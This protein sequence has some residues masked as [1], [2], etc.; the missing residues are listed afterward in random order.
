[1]EEANRKGEGVDRMR[2]D[3]LRVGP[4]RDAAVPCDLNVS[5]EQDKW[6]SRQSVEEDGQELV[7]ATGSYRKDAHP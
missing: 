2:W 1:M 4:R 3:W 6:N 7:E 5:S